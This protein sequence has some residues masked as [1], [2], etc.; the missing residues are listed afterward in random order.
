MAVDRSP[1][2]TGPVLLVAADGGGDFNIRCAKVESGELIFVVKKD[3]RIKSLDLH[4]ELRSC[5]SWLD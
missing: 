2:Y 3:L 5:L 1:R 4:Q